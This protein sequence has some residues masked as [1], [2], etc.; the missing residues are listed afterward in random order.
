MKK[1]TKS[2]VW[3]TLYIAG[4][5][6]LVVAQVCTELYGQA[7]FVPLRV[8]N[9]MANLGLIVGYCFCRAC[10]ARPRRI[11]AAGMAL[12]RGMYIAS[13]AFTCSAA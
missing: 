8:L 6:L 11:K 10:F 13:L 4:A 3:L 9:L 2:A 12:Q 5:C 7:G 1:A